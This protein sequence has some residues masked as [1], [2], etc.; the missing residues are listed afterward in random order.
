[1]TRNT[2]T[3]CWIKR[4]VILGDF[5]L[6]NLVLYAFSQWRQG[7][8]DW[9]V[10]LLNMFSLVA[11]LALIISEWNGHTIIHRRLVSAGDILKR[12]TQLILI[13]V[14]LT[15]LILR[16]V[17]FYSRVGYLVM[18]IGAVLMLSMIML[19]FIERTIIKWY[20]QS[21]GNIRSIT[22]VGDD[23][24]LANIKKKLMTNPTLG[25]RVAGEYKDVDEFIQQVSE[26]K[27]L[28]MGDELYLCVT[29]RE[30]DK[31]KRISHLCDQRL[32]NFFYIPISVECLGINL[33]REM[34]DDI[35]I[36]TLY[37]QPLQIPVNRLIKRFCDV[38]ITL[39]FFGIAVSLFLPIIWVMIK[40]QS[41]G[42]LLFKQQ[43]TGLDGKTFTLYKFR[44]MH[45]NAKA[46]EQ[47]CS[48]NDP[49]KF[50]FGCLM[51]KLS[52]D[53]VPQLW[54]VLKGD[55]SII[56]PRP[57]MLAH[58]DEY[59]QLIDKY[60]VRHFVKPGIT[61]WA[62]VT[63]FRGETKELWQMEERVKRDIWYMENW[64]FWLDIR[65]LWLT[66]KAMLVRNENAY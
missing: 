21:G 41:P 7:M 29:Y 6:L 27:Q 40:I 1:M 34:L 64:S 58:T 20:R 39:F 46:D 38:V 28:D 30:K 18:D 37:E 53:E 60:M 17:G 3:N 11:N 50:K 48:K 25:Y 35:D 63:G 42:P 54:N 33:R 4:F 5:L 66:L 31:I 59:S 45:V 32:V 65:I 15:Y 47:Q 49:R 16:S 61:G 24:E 13:D 56:G 22:L 19:R 23:P 9:S 57:H 51:R 10:N 62:Q 12:V 55:M 2:Q 14:V 36:Y 44:S 43:R 26:D 52:I 8:M